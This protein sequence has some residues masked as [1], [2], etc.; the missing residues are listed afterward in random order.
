MR[1]TWAKAGPGEEID[2]ADLVGG[3]QPV[4]RLVDLLGD[5]WLGGEIG[6]GE[7]RGQRLV[8]RRIGLA[9]W[10][11]VTWEFRLAARNVAAAAAIASVRAASS[12]AVTTWSVSRAFAVQPSQ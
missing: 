12:L 6:G 8:D 10:L 4:Q 11:P 5:Q 2:C 7:D 3:L 9:R 1:G